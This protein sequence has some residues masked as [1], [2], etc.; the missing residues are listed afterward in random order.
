[1]DTIKEHRIKEHRVTVIQPVVH[2]RSVELARGKCRSFDTDNDRHNYQSQS[3]NRTIIE[4]KEDLVPSSDSLPELSMA[5]EVLCGTGRT[6]GVAKRQTERDNAA[7]R[8]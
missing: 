4:T 3:A 5:G 8:F 1:M 2:Q 7:S 6:L